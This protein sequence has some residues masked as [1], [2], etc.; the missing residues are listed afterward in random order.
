MHA[1]MSNPFSVRWTVSGSNLCTGQWEISYNGRLLKLDATWRETDMGTY[2]I[3]SHI[4][5]DDEDFAEGLKEDEWVLANIDW[6][7]EV[8]AAHDIPIDEQHM[9]WLFQAI[10]PHDW[11]CGSCGG[12]I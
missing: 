8:F 3:Y 12:C 11:R 2:G 5:P 1:N 10:N 6:V 7:G 9:R 4:F